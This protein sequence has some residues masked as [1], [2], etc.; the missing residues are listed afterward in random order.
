MPDRVV[1][2]TIPGL[3]S[4]DLGQMPNL[5]SK[6]AG[7]DHA[8]LAPTC[9][10]TAGP[11]RANM[12]TGAT[13]AQHGLVADRLY[14]RERREVDASPQWS[15]FLQAPT[16]WQ[17]LHQHQPETSSA[18]CFVPESHACGA[19]VTCNL[20]YVRGA[21]LTHPSSLASELS[22][23]AVPAQSNEPLWTAKVISALVAY[24]PFDFLW[25][26]FSHVATAGEFD[27]PGSA[28]V[29]ETARAVDAALGRLFSA[30]DDSYDSAP[31]WLVVSP[32]T[33]SPTNHVLY[34]NRLLLEAGL[35]HVDSRAAGNPDVRTSRAWALTDRQISHV[36]VTEPEP[37]ILSDLVQVFSGQQGVAEVLVGEQRSKYDLVHERAGEVIVI[38]TPDSWQ[39]EGSRPGAGPPPSVRGSHGAPAREDRQRG[40]IF[41]SERGVLAG[42]LL[43][44]TDVCDLVL[45]QF[46]I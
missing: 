1:L 16:V 35:L 12:A 43:L 21:L 33:I 18:V 22:W 7:G 29:A 45:R 13:C 42:R 15:D 26:E 2:L 32:Y 41:S 9:P 44:D 11:V 27:G 4:G 39:A 30:I 14:L 36:Y 24:E 37:A 40:V 6:L 23:P 34:P 19:R 46:G 25:C 17:I 28:Q 3:V 20:P 5:R 10:C 31:L 8:T 38:S